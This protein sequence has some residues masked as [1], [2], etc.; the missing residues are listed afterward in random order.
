M[1]QTHNF[2]ATMNYEIPI[3]KGRKFMNRGG[4]LNALFGEFN[5]MWTYSIASGTPTGMSISGVSPTQNN[6]PGY[7]PTYGGVLLMKRPELRD[8]WQDLGTD[9]WTAANQNSM[10]DCG[11]VVLNWGNDCFTY[12]RAFSRGNNGSNLWT[13][14]RI[15]AANFAASKE[16]P[17]KERLKLS[18]RL[19]FQNPF[20][21]YNWGGPNTGLNVQSIANSRTFG[22]NTGGGESGTGTAGYGGTPLMNL[23]L[24]FKW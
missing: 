12:V 22:T 9:R 23:S 18:V 10:I 14:Q 4:V 16:V 7:M 15:I 17:L 5:M 19:D 2:T 8:N 24:A 13:N 20:K 3:G 11:P 6:Y 21:W 1:D